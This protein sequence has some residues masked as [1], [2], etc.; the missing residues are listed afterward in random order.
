MIDSTD[1]EALRVLA[2]EL[3][4][5]AA[6]G[7]RHLRVT[8]DR[9]GHYGMGTPHGLVLLSGQLVEA[10]CQPV[11]ESRSVRPSLEGAMQTSRIRFRSVTRLAD[12]PAPRKPVREM[13]AS[14]FVLVIVV[15]LALAVVGF[16][17]LASWWWS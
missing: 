14:V 7:E 8:E 2:D 16:R 11:G 17:V 15:T 4:R 3:D 12:P 9:D 10:A 13:P 6:H 1:N 5:I